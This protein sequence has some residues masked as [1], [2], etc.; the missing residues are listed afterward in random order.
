MDCLFYHAKGASDFSDGVCCDT[1]LINKVVSQGY[2]L[3]FF[4]LSNNQV[5]TTICGDGYGN[6]IPVKS[7]IA[8]NIQT[9]FETLNGSLLAFDFDKAHDFYDFAEGQISPVEEYQKK[10]TNEKPK[11]K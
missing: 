9:G 6:Y 8:D 4:K 10:L 3:L 7:I 5:L 1:T 11:L 2:T